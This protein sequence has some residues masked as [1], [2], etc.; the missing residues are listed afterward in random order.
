M[1][2]AITESLLR[3]RDGRE[4][5]VTAG[6]L[7][8]DLI[9]AFAITQLSHLLL[10]HQTPYGA[11]ETLVLWFAVWLGWQ[12]TCWVTNWFDPDA[13][14]VRLLLFAAMAVGLL[15][16][17]SLPQAFGERG[18]VFA[19]SYVALQVG[20]S[21][22]VVLWLHRDHALAANFRRIGCWLAISGVFWIAGG[23]AEGHTRLALWIVAVLCEYISPM[24]G[25]AIPGL[26][27]SHISDW[28]SA[29]G[30]HIAERCQLFVILA[31]GESVLV[32]GGTLGG[33]MQWDIPV[34]IAVMVCFLG[35]VAMWW[36]YFDTSA[37][38]ASHRLAHAHEPGQLSAWMH[39]VHVI[40]IA[41]VIVSAAADDLVIAEPAQRIGMASGMLLLAGPAIYL[42]GN[43]LY[44]HML[45]GRLPLSHLGGLAMLAALAPMAPHTDLLMVGGLTSAV[46]CVVAAWESVSR[47]RGRRAQTAA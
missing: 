18:L 5:R 30:G 35:S 34:V 8:F 16:A 17:A 23:L 21:A 22:V 1:K 41:G 15:M 42:V 3:T 24:F 46:M 31:L 40:L 43:A 14:P 19:L 13:L 4:A 26:G 44:K 11:L 37:E 9:Y 39:Y 28:R 47:R 38:V 6:E 33:A 36:V 7:F 20:R 29:E 25:F 27:R 10:H 2:L 32:T 45:Y 12:Y